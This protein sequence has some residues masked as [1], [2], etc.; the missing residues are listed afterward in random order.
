MDLTSAHNQLPL[1]DSSKAKTAFPTPF[2]MF[3]FCCMH[4]GWVNS[5]SA[6]QRVIDA[7]LRDVAGF[8]FPFQD[9]LV[10][11]SSEEVL[12]EDKRGAGEIVRV[13]P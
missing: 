6:F 9:V 11:G 12:G 10:W 7:V 5:N 2:G 1:D 4:Q 13:Q 3:N 8:S